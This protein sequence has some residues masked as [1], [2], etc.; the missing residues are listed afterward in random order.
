MSRPA[1]PRLPRLLLWA[2]SLVPL[3]LAVRYLLDGPPLL[4]FALGGLAVAILA[5]WMRRATEQLAQRAGPSIGGLLNVSFGSA[6]ELIL[7]LFVVFD[8]H[9]DVVRAQIT[10]SIMGTSLLGLGLACYLGGL[11]RERQTFSKG[12]AGL[13]STLL[14]IVFF[15]LVLPAVFDHAQLRQHIGAAGLGLSEE[16]LSLAA[17]G[18]LLALYGGNLIFTLI[19]HRDVFAGAAE[20]EKR[21]GWSMAKSLGVLVAA[22]VGVAVCAELV[23][24]ALESSAATLHV[25][26]L[27]LGIVPL[28]LIGTAADIFATVIFARQNKMDLVMAI[29]LGSAIQ[30]GLVVAPLLV[31]ISWALGRPMNLVFPSALDLFAIGGTAF[32]VNSISSDGETNWLEG[33]LLI[34]AYIL[35]ALAFFFIAPQGAA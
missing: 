11:N 20:V 18:V 21:A 34:G 12:R 17:S 5:E 31:L 6:A 23:S 28:A 19:T 2:T 25:P 26:A 30:I 35:L 13:L 1:A 10:G 27:F 29:A 33:L 24:G 7:M 4:I 9:A 22:T 8:G 32:I 15:A 14:L 16:A 3:V